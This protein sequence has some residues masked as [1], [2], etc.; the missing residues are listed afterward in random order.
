MLAAMPMGS[1]GCWGAWSLA[2]RLAPPSSWDK[3]SAL[4]CPYNN[5]CSWKRKDAG[6]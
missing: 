2:S 1:R 4:Q 5:S 6:M 3:G